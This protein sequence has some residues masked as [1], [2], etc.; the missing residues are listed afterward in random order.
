[1]ELIGRRVSMMG[2]VW[3]GQDPNEKFY[4]V[5]TKRLRYRGRKGE[6]VDGYEVIW[7]DGERERWPYDYLVVALV[8]VEDRLI[9]DS[10][11]ESDDTDES[12]ESED[13]EA[14]DVFTVMSERDDPEDFEYRE[15]FSTSNTGEDIVIPGDC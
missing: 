12:D 9:H 15:M 7:D 14:V 13:E 1:M 5:V 3:P 10:E 6:V 8:P 2:S 4:G 11:S